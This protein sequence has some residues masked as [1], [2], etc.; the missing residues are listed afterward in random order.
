VGKEKI[1]L[2]KKFEIKAEKGQRKK[3]NLGWDK[4]RKENPISAQSIHIGA[5]VGF[6]SL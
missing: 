5:L 2:Q 3:I 4:D 1:K 6:S